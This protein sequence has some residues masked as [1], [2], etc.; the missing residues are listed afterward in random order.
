MPF[1]LHLL[2]TPNKVRYFVD[3]MAVISCVLF[4]VDLGT[5]GDFNDIR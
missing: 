1:M 2:G 5:Y 4:G 3:L